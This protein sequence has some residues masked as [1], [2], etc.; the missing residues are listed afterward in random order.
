L[1]YVYGAHTF[2]VLK[3][4]KLVAT[5]DINAERAKCA[6]EKLNAQRWYTDFDRAIEDGDV[7]AVILV[8][9]GWCHEPQTVAAAKAGK[10]VLCEK[11]M[12]RT[13]EECD[14]MMAACEQSGVTLMIAHMK[15]FNPAFRRV[16]DMIRNG[17]LGEVFTVRGLWD[18]PARRLGADTTFRSDPRSMGGHWHDH[19][20]HMSDLSCWWLG[21]PVTK[22]NG[23]IRSVGEEMISGEDFCIATLIHENGAASCHQTTTYTYRAWHETYEVMGRKGTLVIHARRHTSLSYEPPVI[24]LYDQT[25]GHFNE[26]ATDVTPYLGFDV[27]AD[28]QAANQYLQEL[29]HFCHCVRTGETPLVTGR[30]GRHGVEVINATYLSHFRR[31]WVELPLHDTSE[32]PKLFEA[33]RREQEE[34]RRRTDL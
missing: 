2:R 15:R 19:G 20:A 13:V 29:E 17:D 1:L 6:R 9:P 31:G 24:Q 28:T 33:Y 3:G 14:R 4:G 26:R 25:V 30:D 18:E 7:E 5:V 32:L 23:V 10:H 34:K 11:P 21:S 22:V 16:H 12:A 27:D 8:T